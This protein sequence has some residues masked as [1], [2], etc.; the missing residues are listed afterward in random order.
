[1]V[2]RGV[3][4]CPLSRL[5]RVVG[6]IGEVYISTVDFPKEPILLTYDQRQ[7]LHT[8]V[9]CSKGRSSINY[10]W[11]SLKECRTD[12]MCFP[13]KCNYIF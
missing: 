8:G 13:I 6:R 9:L 2:E 1:M 3:R 4:R 5:L 7:N 12:L 10:L 11:G